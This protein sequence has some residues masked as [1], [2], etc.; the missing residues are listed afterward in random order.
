MSDTPLVV[1]QEI[2]KLAPSALIELYELDLAPDDPASVYKVFFHAGT[3]RLTVP[4]VWQGVSY[5]PLPI[6][7]QGFDK[8]TSGALPRVVLQVANADAMISSVVSN[9][10]DF[11]ASRLTRRR[12]FARFLDAVNFPE[13]NP[14]ANVAAYLPSDIFYMERK[15]SESIR[16]I[17][18]E[19]A[20]RF[21]VEG[22]MLPRRQ[23]MANC[24]PWKYR[25]TECGYHFAAVARANDSLIV[26]TPNVSQIIQEWNAETSYV[27]TDMVWY[28][29]PSRVFAAVAPTV[30]NNPTTSPS[31]WV[32]D[33]CG[34]RL[35]SCVLRWGGFVEDVLPYGG[36]PGSSKTS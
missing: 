33:V 14:E 5:Y 31:Y 7:A 12:T 3:N 29:S 8:Q 23:V 22:V 18:L 28:Q 17:E 26:P 13:G 25:G 1:T 10:D 4:I 34:K 16:G 15:V 21:D 11:L 9:M 35:S 32:E 19:F 6:Q 20:S 24:C 36:F 2:Q 30:G 27:A